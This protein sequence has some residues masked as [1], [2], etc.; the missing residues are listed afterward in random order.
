[1]FSSSI[2]TWLQLTGLTKK[3]GVRSFHS[4]ITFW[5]SPQFE[6]FT[7]CSSQVIC[8]LMSE[9]GSFVIYML[10][11]NQNVQNGLYQILSTYTSNLSIFVLSGLSRS[12][13][14]EMCWTCSS[15]CPPA[16]APLRRWRCRSPRCQCWTAATRRC[17][18]SPPV[19]ETSW[20]ASSSWGWPAVCSLGKGS[21]IPPQ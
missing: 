18:A 12:A 4:S 20:P 6:S 21:K 15:S 10:F 1:M 17:L 7:L 19:S 8:V 13:G 14:G 11:E 16:P 3:W 2:L 5:K 9:Q